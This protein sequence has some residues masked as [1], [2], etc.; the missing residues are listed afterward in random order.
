MILAKIEKGKN[1]G[2]PRLEVTSNTALA[3]YQRD[4]EL[5]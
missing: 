3:L 1:V 4:V 2:M 5:E